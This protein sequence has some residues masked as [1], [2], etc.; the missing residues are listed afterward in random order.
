M[1]RTATHHLKRYLAGHPHYASV[2]V[3][4]KPAAH[5]EVAVGDDVY[6]W[7]RDVYGPNAAIG[8]TDDDRMLAEAVEGVRYVL[9]QSVPRDRFLVTV[10]R[11]LET[12]ADTN[13]GDVKLAAALACCEAIGITLADP[14]RLEPGGA[15]F[16]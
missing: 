1:S 8:G 14:P 2:T 4:A 12:L 6:G 13:V 7:R 9:A 11:V 3:E 15:L 10:T 5:D 16:P